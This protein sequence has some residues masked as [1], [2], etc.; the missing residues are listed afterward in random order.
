MRLAL[1]SLTLRHRRVDGKSRHVVKTAPTVQCLGGGFNFHLVE[2]VGFKTK[3]EGVQ[4]F[5]LIN[6]FKK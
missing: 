2:N 4:D 3:H 6:N 1:R 5:F